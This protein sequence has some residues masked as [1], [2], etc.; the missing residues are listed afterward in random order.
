[1]YNFDHLT[2]GSF[3]FLVYQLGLSLVI[4]LSFWVIAR[5]VN[6]GINKISKECSEE[7]K[8]IIKLLATI[9]K[10]G[11][12]VLGLITALGSMGVNINALVASLGL[13]S[14]ALSFAMKDALS[15]VLA[16]ILILIYQPFK[17]GNEIRIDD[18]AGKVIMI[19]LRYI[20]L[21]IN[22]KTILIPNASILNQAIT[23]LNK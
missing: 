8:P 14:F 5:F 6:F 11:L 10:V 2:F 17:I 16:G 7:K 21:E 4:F 20:T 3:K 1:M 18:Y 23:I 12:L 22:D 19:D 13:S 9:S 15:N